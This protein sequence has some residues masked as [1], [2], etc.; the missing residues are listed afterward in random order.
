M[1]AA[2]EGLIDG[3]FWLGGDVCGVG[4]ID[5]FAGPADDGF[6]NRPG[7][8]LAIRA[9]GVAIGAD[10]EGVVAGGQDGCQRPQDICLTCPAGKPV[11]AVALGGLGE[12]VPGGADEL[13]GTASAWVEPA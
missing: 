8:H 2:A 7:Q 10:R 3:L 4:G 6:A 1:E 5:K 9:A 13:R 12:L 11:G